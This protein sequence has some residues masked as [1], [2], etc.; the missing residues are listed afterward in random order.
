MKKIF[1][2]LVALTLLLNFNTAFSQDCGGYFNF[3]KGMKVEMTSYDKKNKPTLTTRYEVL[4]YSPDAG[5]MSVKFAHEIYDAKNKLLSKSEST[6][7]CVD[8]DY[9]T[10]IRNISAD[11]MPKSPDIKVSV[12]GDQMVYPR[13]LK[14]GDTLKDASVNIKSGFEGGMTIMNMNANIANRKVEAYE[15][16]ET[17]AGKFECAKLTYDLAMKFMGNRKLK[18]VEYLA[19]GVGLVKLEQ[20]DEKGN[21]Q[22]YM[23]LTK[24]EGQ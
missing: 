2:I 18:C 23:E 21:R 7:K 5:G 16:I 22:S 12:T 4:E 10:D 9:Y 11:M 19:K 14:V 20:F 3:K 24:I 8:G 17:P 1:S 15:T 6:G 13:D